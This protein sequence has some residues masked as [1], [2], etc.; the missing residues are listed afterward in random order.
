MNYKQLCHELI[1]TW[2]W[3]V[4]HQSKEF[5]QFL[6]DQLRNDLRLIEERRPVTA[7]RLRTYQS[8]AIYREMLR[9]RRNKATSK[10]P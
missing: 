9:I 10:Q 7:R 2:D 8:H 3:A 4:A 6:I 1:D 5:A